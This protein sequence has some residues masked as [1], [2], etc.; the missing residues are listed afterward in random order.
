VDLAT[1][2]RLRPLIPPGI[3]VVSES[4]FETRQQVR[5]AE[6][7]GVDAI[8]VGTSLMRSPDPAAALRALRGT[9]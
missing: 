5:A 3:L 7:A 9:A 1:T 6:A 4:G 8:L 2:A